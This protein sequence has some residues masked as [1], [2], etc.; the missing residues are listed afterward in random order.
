MINEPNTDP[1]PAPVQRISFTEQFVINLYNYS[2]KSFTRA[3]DS[4]GTS[5]GSDE[6][7]GGVDIPADSGGLEL[8]RLGLKKQVIKKMARIDKTSKRSHTYN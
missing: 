8:S 6:L 7:C 1:I 3:G 5:S 4:D 2:R